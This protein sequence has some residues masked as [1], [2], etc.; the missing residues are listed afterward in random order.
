MV[1]DKAV[2]FRKSDEEVLREKLQMLCDNEE[3]DNI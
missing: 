2:A 1:E 3:K